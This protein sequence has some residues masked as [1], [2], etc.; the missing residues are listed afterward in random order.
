MQLEDIKKL[1]EI[2]RVEMSEEEMND[3][4]STFPS[5]LSYIGEINELATDKAEFVYLDTNKFR[6]DV[7]TN[8]G[9]EYTSLIVGQM[10]DS[11]KGYLKVKQIL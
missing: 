1:A 6:E 8:E 3:I 10:P 4:L 5:I 2:A 11:E 9:G 7:V